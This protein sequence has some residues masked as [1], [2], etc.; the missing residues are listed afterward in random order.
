[1]DKDI[2]RLGKV[3][4]ERSKKRKKWLSIVI[5][6][7]VVALGTTVF[8]LIQPAS[9]ATQD[10]APFITSVID[11]VRLTKEMVSFKDA[12]FSPSR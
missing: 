1:M 9:A 3:R 6:L 5:L 7:A 11:N 2:E 12:S 4:L 10:L 8:Q